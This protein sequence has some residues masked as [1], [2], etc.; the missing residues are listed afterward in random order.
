MATDETAGG[1]RQPQRHIWLLALVGM[2]AIA[3]A[4][5]AQD[6]G[7]RVYQLAP[8]GAKT[9]TIFGVVKRGNEGVEPGS[10][11]LG[12]NI[13]TNLVIFR[14]A[15]TFSVAGRQVSPFVILP[16]GKVEIRNDPQNH[17]SSAS[18]SGLGDIQIGGTLGLIGSPVLTAEDF[19]RYK[20]QLRLALLGRVFFPTGDYS[21]TNR[22]NFGSNRVSYQLGLPFTAAIGTSYLDPSLTTLEILPTVTFYEA[23]NDPFGADKSSK[24]AL[25]S[26]EGHLTHNFSRRWWLSADVLYRKGGETTTDGVAD[27]NAMRGWSAGGSAALA[28]NRRATV[29]LT[30]EQVVARS[31]EGPD[32]WF[33]RTAVVLPF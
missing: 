15:E 17:S 11:Y 9:V 20:P 22:V 4:A 6:D 23:N 5:R 28:L 24:S 16:V 8:E 19:G 13:D 12:S 7:P 1:R 18:S 2:L 21:A 3:G 10:L 27:G 14:Y 25:Y 29:I 26:V 32:G 30:Y 33:F 31:D